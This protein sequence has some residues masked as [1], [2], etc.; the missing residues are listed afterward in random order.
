MKQVVKYLITVAATVAVL[1]LGGIAFVWSGLYDVGA[2]AAHT[3][4]VHTLL[5][6]LRE[7]SISVRAGKL[8]LP[9][10]GDSERIRQ[11]S[12]NYDAMCVGCH[13]AP[14]MKA[15]ELSNGLYPAPPNLSTVTVDAAKAFWVIKHGIKASGMPA[16][17]KSMADDYIW[18]MAALVQV[19]PSL[20]ATQY[21]ALVA[22]SGGHSHG[23][24][25]TAPHAHADGVT[26]DQHGSDADN[27]MPMDGAPLPHVHGSDAASP[28]HRATDPAP[29]PA[30]DVHHHADGTE[31]VHA[32]AT[33]TTQKHD[34]DEHDH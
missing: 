2:D 14:G 33:P 5:Q 7:R 34:A 4:P 17:G 1:A 25:E 22:S 28:D 21:R 23:G 24:G 20:D 32:A 9:N 15:T 6:T 29:T 30:Q 10:L 26:E 12:G 16:W 19:L 11:G 27:H 8:Q 31:H 18:N 3:K 13:L